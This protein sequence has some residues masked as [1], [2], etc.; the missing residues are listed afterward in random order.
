MCK[1]I[2][3][4]QFISP[5]VFVL[6]IHPPKFPSIVITGKALMCV[7]HPVCTHKISHDDITSSIIGQKENEQEVE[8]S[9]RLQRHKDLATIIDQNIT[10]QEKILQ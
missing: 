4:H 3:N 9:Q 5:V 6:L 1:V 10:A 2:Y 7:I 8:M